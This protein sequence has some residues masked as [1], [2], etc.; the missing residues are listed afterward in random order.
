M[1]MRL[2]RLPLVLLS[3]LHPLAADR[4][5]LP[6]IAVERLTVK[7]SPAMTALVDEMNTQMR[8]RHAVPLFVRAYRA[9]TL[10]ETAGE[11]F[12]LYPAVSFAALCLQQTHFAADPD[13]ASLRKRFTE[14]P[15]TH[16]PALLK[17]VRFDGA[18]RPGWLF[19]SLVQ[20]S[21]EAALL[22][23]LAAWIPQAEPDNPQPRRLNVFRVIVGDGLFTHLVSFNLPNWES[24]V[25]LLDSFAQREAGSL[26]PEAVTIHHQALY[27]ELA[28]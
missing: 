9:V 5:F 22:K 21:N 18:H 26:F 7:D 8:Q 1:M 16:L 3:L 17:A 28:E 25:T 11:A 13:L 24:L 15:R 27:H 2:A 23:H 6:A 19:N 20:T 4:T 10:G 14:L 12:V